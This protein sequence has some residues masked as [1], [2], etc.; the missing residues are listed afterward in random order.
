M[1]RV[2]AALV[3]AAVL[4]VPG[5]ASSSGTHAAA[6]CNIT[7]DR[8]LAGTTPATIEFVNATNA[9]VSV[10][11][12][13][14]SGSR[15][16]WFRLQPGVHYVQHTSIGHAWLVTDT[17]GTCIGF[18]IADQP[19]K[20][21]V[22]TGG[23]GGSTPS[24]PSTPVTFT[25]PTGDSSRGP[26]IATVAVSNDGS[27]QLFFVITAANRTT[28]VP[29]DD[30]VQFC[31]DT[32]R[33]PSTG[34]QDPRR[35]P[36][37]ADYILYLVYPSGSIFL[38]WNGSGLESAPRNTLT[39]SGS[40]PVTISI[41][42]SELGNT[43]GFDFQLSTEPIPGDT[44]P[45]SGTWSYTLQTPK[46]AAP[47]APAPKPAAP[48]PVTLSIRSVGVQAR[49]AVPVAGFTFTV[50]V[51]SITLSTG[52]RVTPASA[53]C[54]ARLAGAPLKGSGK[55]GCTFSIPKTAGGKRLAITVTAGYGGKT[56]VTAVGYT[57]RTAPS[58]TP[59]TKPKPPTTPPTPT[60]KTSCSTAGIHYSGTTSEDKLLCFTIA[61]NGKLLAEAKIGY[62][63]PSCTGTDLSLPATSL[64]TV[65][66]TSSGS[67]SGR[68]SVPFNQSVSGQIIG[69]GQLS[70][71]TMTVSGSFT[72]VIQ[73]SGTA[74]GTLDWALESGF[75]TRTVTCK[76][77]EPATWRATA[78]K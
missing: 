41:N 27:G 17:G 21:Y 53:R 12:L 63:N 76:R 64:A 54:N 38:R 48:K 24:T 67:L 37:G 49:P 60:P 5:P 25:D 18:V 52:K 69:G 77:K 32:D 75:G 26:D 20:Q 66:V 62:G 31:F 19:A 56:K 9:F 23:A 36:P 40:N 15:Q 10:Y 14:F 59:T 55:G 3:G 11:W 44:A 42:R 70:I 51:S 35:C 1:V 33:N 28:L 39:G 34:L 46:P 78:E 4:L 73:P 8:S 57:V 71:G 2:L 29:D 72:G 47:T 30:A 61:R 68:F 22:I 7:Q 58:P 6:G 43:S 65:A 16:F 45:N 50:L 13:D 74:T